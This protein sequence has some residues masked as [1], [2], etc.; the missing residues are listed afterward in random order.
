MN[1]ILSG[2][3][4]LTRTLAREFLGRMEDMVQPSWQ[5]S[6]WQTRGNTRNANS[7]RK[8]IKKVAKVAKVFCSPRITNLKKKNRNKFFSCCL[9]FAKICLCFLR[10]ET[11]FYSFFSFFFHGHIFFTCR[12]DFLGHLSTWLTFVIFDLSPSVTCRYDIKL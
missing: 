5:P 1:T 2:I 7:G 6:S 9:K 3:A 10:L 4:L 11:Y 12:G 8:V